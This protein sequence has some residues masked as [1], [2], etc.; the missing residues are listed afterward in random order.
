MTY[1]GL[2]Y[3]NQ[4]IVFEL[5]QG[6]DMQPIYL[7]ISDKQPLMVIPESE[8]HMD[9]HPVLTYSYIIYKDDEAGKA[10]QSV[11][12]DDLLSP[13]RIKNSNYAGRLLFEQPGRL[14]SYEADGQIV[15]TSTE[16]EQIIEELTHYRENPTIWRI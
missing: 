13:E 16:V 4:K 7:E 2:K 3:R 12:T 5:K 9:G 15:L 11:S 1:R 6:R 10:L 8:G 14:F